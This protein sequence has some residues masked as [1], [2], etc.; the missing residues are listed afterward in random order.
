MT[1][2]I[3]KA[4]IVCCSNGQEQTKKEYLKKGMN[5]LTEK[6]NSCKLFIIHNEFSNGFFRFSVG[7]EDV[8][9]IKA[10]IKQ[11]LEKAGLGAC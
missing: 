4:G 7:I 9:D 3:N 2:K 1:Q 10:D 6:V 11:A 8:E 5:N